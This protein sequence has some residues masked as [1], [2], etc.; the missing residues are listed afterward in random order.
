MSAHFGGIP[1]ELL[2]GANQ[3]SALTHGDPLA[4]K[5]DLTAQ[6]TK[7]EGR[8]PTTLE[9]LVPEKAVSCSVLRVEIQDPLEETPCESQSSVGLHLQGELEQR[10]GIFGR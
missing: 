9:E 8:D 5:E 1:G 3:L 4:P 6:L 10:F 7:L 2:L